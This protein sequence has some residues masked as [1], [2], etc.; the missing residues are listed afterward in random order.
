MRIVVVLPAPLGPRKPNTSPA[1]TSNDTSATASRLPNRL[2]RCSAERTISPADPDRTAA[3]LTES[4]Y[5]PRSHGPRVVALLA[6]DRSPVRRDRG[7]DSL[8]HGARARSARRRG[9]APRRAASR[10]ARGRGCRAPKDGVF[11]ILVVGDS[12]AKGTGDETGKGFGV[13][14]LEDF[15]KKGR[16]EITNLAV[17]GMESP[18][19]LALVE[20]ANVRALAAGASLILVSVGG[21]DLSHSITRG[22]APTDVAEAVAAS[23]TSYAQNLRAILATLREANPTAP[24][25]R[26][27]PLRSLR[28]RPG[29]G[30]HRRLGH[31]PVEHADRGDRTRI[32]QRDASSPPSTSSRA[33]PTA[34]PPTTTIPTAK[35]YAEIARRMLQVAS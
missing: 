29:P 5:H 34:S 3:V 17:N 22:A 13:N 26:P 23:R 18:E 35:A 30:T 11:R 2:V 25:L 31:P 12:L 32:S 19:V 16:A 33:A 8:R 10:P 6:L 14:V 4:T 21:N 1:R 24:H 27:R 15:R 9:S 20:S 28:R 7:G